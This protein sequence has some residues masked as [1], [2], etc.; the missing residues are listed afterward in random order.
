M[1]IEKVFQWYNSLQSVGLIEL[2]KEEEPKKKT[3]K[4]K[5]EDE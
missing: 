3:T 4:T 5:K 2:P 1:Y